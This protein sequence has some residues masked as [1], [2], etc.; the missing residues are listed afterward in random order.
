MLAARNAPLMLSELF[1]QMRLTELLT[2][3]SPAPLPAVSDESTSQQFG[4]QGVIVT[5]AVLRQRNMLQSG[6]KS[7]S[8]LSMQLTEKSKRT[9]SDYQHCGSEEC[10][11]LHAAVSRCSFTSLLPDATYLCV[12]MMLFIIMKLP[13]GILICIIQHE[14]TSHM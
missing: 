1:L 7:P 3:S 6:L 13:C 10:K 11:P 5:P 2:C 14:P 8:F 9:G 4:A 12:D